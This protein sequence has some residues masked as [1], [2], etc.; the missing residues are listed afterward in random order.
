M[1]SIIMARYDY[2]TKI[3]HCFAI[4]DDFGNISPINKQWYFSYNT[5]CDEI[6]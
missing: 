2:L 4:M 5:F 6:V 3:R 1:Q